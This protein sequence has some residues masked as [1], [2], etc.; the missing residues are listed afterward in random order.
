MLADGGRVLRAAPGDR[1]QGC[2]I[3]LPSLLLDP[4]SYV[5]SMDAR[6]GA[7]RESVLNL[8][9]VVQQGGAVAFERDSGGI[10]SRAVRSIDFTNAA[11]FADA[12]VPFEIPY[13]TKESSIVLRDRAGTAWTVDTIR[14]APDPL[15]TL[16]AL[17][18]IVGLL[19]GWQS[20]AA[21]HDRAAYL[22]LLALA[23]RDAAT[24]AVERAADQYLAAAA[25]CPEL[26]APAEGLYNL[27]DKLTPPQAA[28]AQ[29]MLADYA[30]TRDDRP[31]QSAPAVFEPGVRLEG[32]RLSTRR[33]H[34]NDTF[35]I[36]L[37]WSYDRPGV[38]LDGL[39]VW[40]HI[41]NSAGE[42]AFQCDHPL[43]EDIARDPAMPELK[44]AFFE[45]KV[46]QKARLGTYR[47][48]VG[49]C[50]ADG[51]KR[52]KLKSTELKTRKEGVILPEEIKIV[53]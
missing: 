49:L 9:M 15:A 22:P 10:I 12:V 38:D 43:A 35:G 37:Y 14:I 36:N 8:S 21:V 28:A 5:L 3:G 19:R 4:G 39:A 1:S 20:P 30:A 26:A 51:V 33:M 25:L 13:G 32:Y 23:G 11:D 27:R 24:G 42:V 48:Q 50:T 7:G 53:L 29:S 47:V 16:N 41:I 52:M 18:R 45:V 17:G 31:I 34:R 2:V 46:P 6:P 44:P 40:V